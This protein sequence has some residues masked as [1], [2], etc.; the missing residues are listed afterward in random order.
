[1][2]RS[3]YILPA[4]L[5]LL[6]AAAWLPRVEHVLL[7]VNIRPDEG[8]RQQ[9]LPSDSELYSGRI[10]FLE[11]ED[12]NTQDY[13]MEP[14]FWTVEGLDG[15]RIMERLADKAPGFRFSAPGKYVVR[16][17]YQMRP[18]A[19]DTLVVL[20]GDRLDVVWPE[21]LKKG[22]QLVAEDRSPN[23]KAREWLLMAGTDTI[24]R[25]SEERFEWKADSSGDHRLALTI[26]TNSGLV[27]RDS[28]EVD[29]VPIV[30]EPQV[31]IVPEKR[32]I[33]APQTTTANRTTT[34]PPKKTVTPTQVKVP[35]EEPTPVVPPVEEVKP[36]GACFG[37]GKRTTVQ[38]KLNVGDPQRPSVDW[39]STPFTFQVTPK[40]DCSLAS[41]TYWGNYRAGAV[42]V[43]IRCMDGRCTGQKVFTTDVVTA[44]DEYKRIVQNLNTAVLRAGLTYEIT[45]SPDAARKV[46]LG[47]APVARSSFSNDVVEVRF[48]ANE[49]AVFDLIFKR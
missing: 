43:S 21:D 31:V 29:V 40:V 32:R 24:L 9:V 8:D 7:G 2:Q 13:D 42:M 10:Y 33:V 41:Y 30:I 28:I 46:E 19:L 48:P 1:M 38:P 14:W 20:E 37:K 18:L 36:A 45:L 26:T 35:I 4:L 3:I 47:V 39:S 34:K 25:G 12:A 49:S 6:G 17:W 22:E 44:N 15:K 5:L 11:V 27:L 16:S 23:V